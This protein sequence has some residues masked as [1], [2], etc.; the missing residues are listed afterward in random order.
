MVERDQQRWL[1]APPNDVH[2]A[3]K[4]ALCAKYLLMLAFALREIEFR[5]LLLREQRLQCQH[6]QHR[7]GRERRELRI[8]AKMIVKNHSFSYRAIQ[9][10]DR[11]SVQEQQ[12]GPHLVLARQR[13]CGPKEALVGRQTDVEKPLL[14]GLGR[15]FSG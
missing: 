6:L 9:I 5:E 8:I 13:L 3:A 4:A 14:V 2:I 7:A 1:K 10:T 15:D 11:L 12:I